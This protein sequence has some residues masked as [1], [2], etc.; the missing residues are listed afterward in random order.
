MTE[1]APSPFKAYDIR[2]QVPQSLNDALAER[3]GEGYAAIIQPDGP[4]AIGRDMRLSSAGMAQALQ[5][6]LNRSG[7]ATVDIG[8]C[9]T[10]MVY[11]AAS[12]AGMGGGVMVTASHNPADYNG[13]KMVR[14]L[15]IPISGDTGLK[16]IE[17]WILAG[18]QTGAEGT[19]AAHSEEDITD[20]YVQR[21]LDSID[22]E[23]IRPFKVVV[24]AGNGCAGPVFDAIA[25]HLPLDIVRL[26]HEPDGHFPNGV[27]NPLLNENREETA[28]AV[29]AA[30]ADLGIAWDGDFDR[31]FFF[32]ADGRFIEGYYLVGL[33]AAEALKQHPGGRIVLDPRL[34]WNTLDL[35]DQAGGKA[36]IN[37]SGH[38]FIK[39]RMRRE[40]AIYGGEMS[41]HHYFRDFAYCDSGMLPWL[42]L[43][44]I[45]SRSGQ[46]L[47]ELVDAR[48]QAFPCSGEINF[49]VINT[50]R[51]MAEVLKRYS[52]A[53]ASLDQTDGISLAF[54]DWRF[55][56]RASNTEPV[57]RLNVE[58][59]AR[60]ELLTERT[61]ELAA[62]ITRLGAQD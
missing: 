37:K 56:L 12:R 62:L 23:A 48:I 43:L 22:I 50:E 45:M 9:G 8:L 30:G 5:R 29:R 61:D 13:M 7:I 60:P 51:V 6:G 27:P 58:T 10:E 14:E 28:A 18:S 1:S 34:T 35:V 44:Q 41:A 20:A 31:C 33:F 32:D 49:A 46:S 26:H 11:H 55:N 3:I 38:A 59:R 4:V 52:T 19:L 40:D 25:E 54:A 53:E 39:E 57:I 36:L 16:D 24:N 17:Q 47:A 15:A 2:G 42:M 21:M